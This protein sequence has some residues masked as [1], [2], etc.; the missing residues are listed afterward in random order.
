MDTCS[1]PRFARSQNQVLFCASSIVTEL[2]TH[3]ETG[4]SGEM[5]LTASKRRVKRMNVTYRPDFQIWAL[6]VW[7]PMG[8]LTKNINTNR[9]NR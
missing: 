4:S 6:K 2:G 7:Q 3:L 8:K 9:L 1:G 5:R